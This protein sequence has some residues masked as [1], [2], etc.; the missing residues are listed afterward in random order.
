M[1]ARDLALDLLEK[2]IRQPYGLSY[3]SLKLDEVWDPLRHNQR[4]EKIVAAL[5]PKD[6]EVSLI[7]E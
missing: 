3:G 4:F 2:E 6:A 7:I 5:A 1:P